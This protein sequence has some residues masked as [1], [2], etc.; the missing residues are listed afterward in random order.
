MAYERKN[1]A[2]MMGYVPGEQ[3]DAPDILKLNTNENPYPPSPSVSQALTAFD[4]ERLRQYPPPTARNLQEAIANKH[5]LDAGNV[6]V[7]NGGDELLR[8]AIAT[9]VE[10]SETI[11]VARPTY[12]LYQVLADAHGCSMT[13]FELDSDWRLPDNYGM[14]LNEAE[15]KLSFLVNPHAPSG[16]LISIKDIS[17]LAD[18]FNGVLLLDEATSA[19][20][21][22]SE[23]KVQDALRTLMKGRTTL[24]VAHRLSTIIDADIIHVLDKGRIIESGSHDELLARGEAY[25]RLW[26][27]QS[28]GQEPTPAEIRQA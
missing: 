1:I 24:V 6:L 17:A 23:R 3:I 14:L 28:G 9:F 13:S 25:A 15:A 21:S 5:G 11:A 26:R 19:L 10:A 2:A 16:T 4:T 27:M 20:D 22:E 8:M 12:T 7:T 18:T